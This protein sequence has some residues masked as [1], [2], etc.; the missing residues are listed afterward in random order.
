MPNVRILTSQSTGCY[1]DIR[2]S[3]EIWMPKLETLK[4]EDVCFRKVTL[5]PE[6]TPNNDELYMQ[7][8]PDKCKLTVILPRLR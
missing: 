5:N 8:I 4:L 2:P 7:N 3:L 6:L 1:D